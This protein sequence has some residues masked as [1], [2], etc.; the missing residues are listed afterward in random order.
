M[1]S[2]L[3]SCMPAG[4]AG[5]VDSR[6]DGPADFLLIFTACLHGMASGLHPI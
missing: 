5:I 4:Y 3:L 2:G 1:L 6:P